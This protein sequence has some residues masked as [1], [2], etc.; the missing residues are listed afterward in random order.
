MAKHEDTQHSVLIVTSAAQFEAVA[1]KSLRGFV[2]TDCR[3]SASAARRCILERYY[4]LVII[5]GPL[6]DE[7][8]LQLALD[9]A[10]QCSASILL[11]VSSEIFEDAQERLTDHGVLVLA[12]PFSLG[13]LD[14]AIRFLLAVQNRR[15]LLEK[16]IRTVE[17]KMEEIRIV[18]RAKLLLVEKRKMTE[19]EAHRWIGKQA[20]DHGISRRRAAENLLDEYD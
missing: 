10:D 11:V 1:R 6:P 12:K 9:A 15:H 16:R 8:G 20:M 17:E 3:Q 2:Y 19:E 14:K 18:S 13:R 4:D 5:N 7:Q